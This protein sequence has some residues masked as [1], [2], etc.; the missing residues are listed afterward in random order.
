MNI[1][2][3]A[4]C[5]EG[6]LLALS[7]MTAMTN[8]CPGLPHDTQWKNQV[9]DSPPR[10]RAFCHQVVDECVARLAPFGDAAPEKS[11]LL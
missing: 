9:I 11:P 2:E 5:L 7:A 6:R 8:A 1:L 10:R 4:T 3:D